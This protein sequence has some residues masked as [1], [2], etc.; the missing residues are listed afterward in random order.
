V[1]RALLITVLLVVAAC[2]GQ[3]ESAAT[4]STESHGGATTTHG[5]V[6]T[7]HGTTT[8]DSF[9]AGV[10]WQMFRR[11]A[12]HTAV[13]P[14]IGSIDAIAGPSERWSYRISEA[15]TDMRWFSTFPL[16]DLDGDGGLEVVVTTADGA[17]GLGPR[18]I[19]LTERDGLPEPL[20]TFEV[21]NPEGGVDQ[22]GAALVDA[23]GDGLPDVV[24]SSRDGLVRALDGVTG[25]IIWEYDSGRLMESGPMIADLDGDGVP[26]VIQVTDC[27]LGTGCAPSGALMV[28]ASAPGTTDN[29]P[30]WTVEFPWK[31]D[32]G[33]PAIA[34]LDP[35]DGRDVA[36]IVFGGWGG[37]LMVIWKAPGEEVRRA[38]LVLATLDD[39]VPDD[40]DTVAMRT[41]PLIADFGDGPTAVFGWMPDYKNYRVA[42]QSAVGI[43]VNTAEGTVEFS[44]RWTVEE[45]AWKSSP[46]LLEAGGRRLVVAGAG[47]ALGGFGGL[48]C[49]DVAGRY[50]ARDG[51]T[52][53][54]AWALEM[55]DGQGDLRGSV[56]VADVDGDGRPEVIAGVG[57]GGRLLAI[58]GATGEIEWERQ[59]GTNLYVSPSLA[60]LDGDGSLE[61]VIGSLDGN[62]YVFGG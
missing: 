20:W 22:Y 8:H 13:V 10:A 24:F 32:S 38:D 16:G 29:Q 28:L 12:S 47:Y 41:S 40:S 7:T 14:G 9:A 55:P 33:E 43:S 4:S 61:I 27:L 53:E 15:S 48:A 59:L 23:D 1:R 26:E 34:D 17:P 6:G 37:Q 60:D 45:D 46:A 25:E 50:V 58:D 19:A 57:C 35:N 21:P 44:P 31:V 56:A 2:G 5:T 52:G 62:V 42:R 51:R 11:D 3:S 36:Q 18:V 30:L 39:S 49:D 54:L